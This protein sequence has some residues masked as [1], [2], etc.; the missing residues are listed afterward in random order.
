MIELRELTCGYGEKTIL[1]EID[2]SI[3]KGQ[4]VGII[5]PNGSGKTTMLRAM[6]RL[7]KPSKGTVLL[8]GVDMKRLQIGDV[9]R[10]IAVVSQNMPLIEMTVREFVLLGRIPYYGKLQFFEKEEDAAIAGR[11]MEM[12]GILHLKDALMS[13]MSAGEVQL[14]FIARGLTQQP[15]ALLLDEP[16]SH[17]D[18]THQA[19]ILDLVKRLNRQEGLTVVIILH[20]LNLA[21]EYCESLVLM[22][23]GRIRKAGAPAEV[24]DYETI[25]DVYKTVVVVRQ[26]PL[27]LKPFV[28]IV[29][30]EVREEC[31]KGS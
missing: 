11:V 2:L 29:S 19:A 12:T 14:A 18:I 10:K 20:D 1:R 23:G 3:G 15:E 5:G 17:L 6:T 24:I 13:E 7:I 4:F 26:N 30:E 27:S 9:A 25:E 28:M 16:T 31:E 8:D 21:S 22:D